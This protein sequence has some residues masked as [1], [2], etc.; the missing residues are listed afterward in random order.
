MLNKN[1]LCLSILLATSIIASRVYAPSIG[2]QTEEPGYAPAWGP[3]QLEDEYVRNPLN[4]S[5]PLKIKRGAIMRVINEPAFLQRRLLLQSFTNTPQNTE[6]PRYQ[7][8]VQQVSTSTDATSSIA[9]LEVFEDVIMHLVHY[10]NYLASI[11]GKYMNIFFTGIKSSWISPSEWANP[12]SWASS[13]TSPE[14]DQLM[15]ELQQLSKLASRHGLYGKILATRMEEKANS[16]LYWKSRMLKTIATLGAIVGGIYYKDNIIKG[17]QNAG[18]YME[19]LKNSAYSTGSN[20]VSSV[21][22]YGKSIHNH[23]ANLINSVTEYGKSIPGRSADWISSAAEYGK[24]IPSRFYGSI[25]S[26]P[27]Q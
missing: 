5:G 7:D 9:V 2:I 12:S 22:E 23:S 27:A 6:I 10:N 20:L 8:I 14:I 13:N 25:P 17:L 18:A 21:A 19:D 1:R 4:P 11:E 3:L 15:R 24:S 26:V 16:Y